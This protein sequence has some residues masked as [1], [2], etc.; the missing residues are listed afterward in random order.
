MFFTLDFWRL[1]LDCVENVTG[2]EFHGHNEGKYYF[3]SAKLPL[4][5]YEPTDEGKHFYY[6]Y[7][8]NIGSLKAQ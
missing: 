1:I 2:F 7:L 6:D 5:Q 3:N 8:K 4:V